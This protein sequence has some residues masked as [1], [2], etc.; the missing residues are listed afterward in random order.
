MKLQDRRAEIPVLLDCELSHAAH[1]NHSLHPIFTHKSPDVFI[2]KLNVTFRPIYN[3][4]MDVSKRI[5]ARSL[6]GWRCRPVETV[7][8]RN[9][10]HL[11]NSFV[12]E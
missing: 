7:W 1:W 2:V 3:P 5:V 9:L 6:R 12:Y 10:E 8:I 11:R 4:L